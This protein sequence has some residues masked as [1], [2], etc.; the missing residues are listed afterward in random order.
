MRF[1]SIGSG[2]R[3]NG[4]LVQDNQ[5]SLL[6]DLGFTIIET[7][8]RLVRMGVDPGDITAILV[9]HEHSDHI[10]G[11]GPFS[12]KYK[13]PV[14]MTPG[15]LNPKKMGI[16][17]DLQLIN[18]HE[19]FQ[20]DALDIVPVPVPHDAREPCQYLISNDTHTLGILTDLGHITAHVIEKYRSCHGLLI[21]SNHDPDMLAQGPY[22]Y[23]LKV[24]VGG[25]HGH[26]SN[27]QTAELLSQIDLSRLEH[28][29]IAH[30]SEKNNCQTKI[31]AEISAVLESWSG[32]LTIADQSTGFDWVT[33]K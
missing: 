26:L 9:T 17:P 22:P 8:R 6:I 13:V 14:Y 15:T 16:L 30:I 23:A 24:R 28:L 19:P 11:V 31:A 32:A 20:I 18:C 27:K 33:F 2:S 12:R 3:G 10:N 21:E 5:T 7:E 1:A 29:V 25:D 4:T